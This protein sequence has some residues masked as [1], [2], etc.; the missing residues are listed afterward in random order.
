VICV[1]GS[2]LSARQGDAGDTDL[3]TREGP[4]VP[5]AALLGLV[6]RPPQLRVHH[7]RQARRAGLPVTHRRVI[8]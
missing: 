6:Q 8:T 4:Q 1:L 7:A 3:L 2:D 5:G